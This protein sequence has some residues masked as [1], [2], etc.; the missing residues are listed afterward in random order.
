MK[1]AKDCRNIQ[2]IRNG[3]DEIDRQIL[4]SFAKRHEYVKAIVAFKSDK[5][6]I[7]APERQQEVFR[8]RREWAEELGLDPD[9]FEEIYRTLIDWNVQKELEILSD[10]EKTKKK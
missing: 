8:K 10:T 1:E 5:N 4:A 9:L 2:E 7:V 6:G 3:I